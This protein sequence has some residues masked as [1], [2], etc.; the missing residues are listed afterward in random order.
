MRG[1]TILSKRVTD[2]LSLL[3]EVPAL[4]GPVFLVHLAGAAHPQRVR[5][6]IAGDHG[7][8]REIRALA[9]LHRRYQRGIAADE[10]PRSDLGR[11]LARS[12]VVAGD[13]A[14]AD[15]HPRSDIGIA[16]EM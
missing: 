14:G 13:G 12:I 10:S 16:Q 8:R 7:P 4:S 3:P 6:D 5:R 11:V 15:V 1:E 2:T 9:D